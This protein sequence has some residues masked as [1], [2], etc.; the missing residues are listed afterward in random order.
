MFNSLR[1]RLLAVLAA[2]LLGAPAAGAAQPGT[3][4]SAPAY[5]LQPGD[6]VRVVIWRE[7]DLSGEFS[8]NPAGRVTLPLLGERQVE[9]IRLDSLQAMLMRD[10]LVYLRN[11]SITITPLRRVQVLGEVGKPGLYSVDP[12]ITVAGAV[13]LAGGATSSGD[14]NRIRILRDG[15]VYSQRVGPGTA[16]TTADIRSGDQIF[17][18]RRSWFDRNSTFLVSVLLS[19]SGILISIINAN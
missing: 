10:Y 1:P 14:L 7:E 6:V 13:A 2:A 3:A 12:T 15:Q 8:V 4:P 11:P 18:E 5:S 17:V 19:V 16:L 9:G